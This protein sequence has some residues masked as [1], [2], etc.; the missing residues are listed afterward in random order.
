MLKVIRMSTGD[1]GNEAAARRW[2]TDCQ[3]DVQISAVKRGVPRTATEWTAL[4]KIASGELD[5][6]VHDRTRLVELGLIELAAGA[7][8]L[9]QHGRM[10]LGLAE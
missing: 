5:V 7:P 10:T 3:V 9:T 6:A 1:T 2:S 4:V 8:T